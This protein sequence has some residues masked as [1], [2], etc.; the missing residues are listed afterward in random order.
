MA[1]DAGNRA[2]AA[3][4]EERAARLKQR[5]NEQFW[6]PDK[7]Y[8][9]VALDKDKRPVDACTSNMRQCLWYG[10]VDEDK[11]PVVAERLMSPEMFSGWGVRT[12]ASNMV[13]TTRPATTTVPSGPTVMR[14]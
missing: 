14:S 12:L 6:L 8:Y 1:H 3:E 2:L 5:F 13:P 7:G 10:I 11:V 9:A 4:L